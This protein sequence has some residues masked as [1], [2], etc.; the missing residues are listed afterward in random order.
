MFNRVPAV[1]VSV[2]LALMLFGCGEK[3]AAPDLGS[4]DIFALQQYVITNSLPAEDHV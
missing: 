4:Q 1:V 2:F 3:E